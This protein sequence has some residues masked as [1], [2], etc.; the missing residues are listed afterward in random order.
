MIT[1]KELN[2]GQR[3]IKDGNLYIKITPI[4]KSCCPDIT[5]NAI[6]VK[7]GKVIIAQEDELVQGADE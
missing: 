7:T 3:F 4:A 1:F 6:E 2:I 5:A